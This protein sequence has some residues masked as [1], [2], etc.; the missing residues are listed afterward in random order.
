MAEFK[1]PQQLLDAA[2]AVR[3]AG[4]LRVDAYSPFP[5]EGLAEAI[6]MPRDRIPLYALVGGLIG[7]IGIYA[8]QWYAAVI[9]YPFNSGGRPL[10]SWPAFVPATFEMTV[11]GA[12]LCAFIGMLVANGLPKLIHPVFNAKEFDLASRDRFFLCIDARDP[13]FDATST[14]DL[15]SAQAPIRL[16][17][18]PLEE[19]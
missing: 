2:H 5:V 16:F 10:N 4:L 1:E 15:L 11:L 9:D 17:D 18:V 7:G 8:L 12:A 6:G 14:R 13:L 3:A 19:P